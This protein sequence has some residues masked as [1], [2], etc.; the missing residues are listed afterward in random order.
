M[1]P[2]VPDGDGGTRLLLDIWHPDCWTLQVTEEVLAGLLGHGVHEVEGKAQG[3]FTA[4]AE[5]VTT[6]AEL[7]EAIETSPLTESITLLPDAHKGDPNKEITGY[8]THELVVVYEL[9]NS[10]NDPLVS[11]GF[12]PDAPV[13]MYDGREYWPVVVATEDREEIQR[14]LDE[15]REE[16]GAEIKTVQICSP[17]NRLGSGM[18]PRDPLSDRQ[19]EVIDLARQMGYYSWP[20]SVSA[21]DL[22][23]EFDISEST[24][25]EHLRKA[26]AKLFG[27]PD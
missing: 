3:R 17:R 20:R 8:A 6:L 1:N 21:G 5:S 19:R 2:T 13:R 12:I 14:R 16:H 25:L 7:L 4:Y 22:A 26:E 23:E 27:K 11:R 9:T 18:F 10:I 24:L 15:I